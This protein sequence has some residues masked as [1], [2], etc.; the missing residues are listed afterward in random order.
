MTSHPDTLPETSEE[1]SSRADYPGDPADT[2]IDSENSSENHSIIEP[3]ADAA[4]ADNILV[5]EVSAWDAFTDD[6]L[7]KFLR[8]RAL[9]DISSSEAY[10]DNGF[11]DDEDGDDDE[12][13]D[14]DDDDDEDDDDDS[15]YND[16]VTLVQ[17]VCGLC[18]FQLEFSEHI[19]HCR[20]LLSAVF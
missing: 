14:D 4:S 18:R 17:P 12:E 11:N 1:E 10:S 9:F 13:D 15:D 8:R 19:I 7:A 20:N 6:E 16:R 3:S 5:D 2:S